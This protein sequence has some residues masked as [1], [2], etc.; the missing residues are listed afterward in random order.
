MMKQTSEA[1]SCKVP[2]TGMSMFFCDDLSSRPSR[3]IPPARRIDFLFLVLL[4]QLQRARAPQR[5]TSASLSCSALRDTP[6]G[7][8]SNNFTCQKQLQLFKHTF[9]CLNFE[10]LQ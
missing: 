7:K 10:I 4:L 5:A 8:Q 3:G 2:T 6:L 9:L 1:H